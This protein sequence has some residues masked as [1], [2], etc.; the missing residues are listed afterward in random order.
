[1]MNMNGYIHMF[2]FIILVIFNYFQSYT[3]VHVR[4]SG[5][6]YY[7]FGQVQ[8]VMFI[9][10]NFSVMFKF[11]GHIHSVILNRSSDYSSK[12]HHHFQF[13]TFL[14]FFEF[15]PGTQQSRVCCWRK[16][17][18]AFSYTRDC[19]LRVPPSP[20]PFSHTTSFPC[21]QIVHFHIVSKSWANFSVRFDIQ[22]KFLPSSLTLDF[23]DSV[24]LFH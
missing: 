5:N 23:G 21:Q 1:M 11:F 19:Q 9:G 14:V 13:D 18:F 12:D 10:V 2:M 17:A 6:I 8:W 4:C 22:R 20:P 7:I 16:C 3:K 15:E 24:L